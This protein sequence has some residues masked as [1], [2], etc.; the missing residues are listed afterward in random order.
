MYQNGFL[1]ALQYSTFYDLFEYPLSNIDK[2]IAQ[3]DETLYNICFL[4]SGQNVCWFI[5]L[6]NISIKC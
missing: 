5:T 4:G 6:G 2:K 3:I 1:V